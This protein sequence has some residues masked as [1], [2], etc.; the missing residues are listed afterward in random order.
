MALNRTKLAVTAIGFLR[1]GTNSTCVFPHCRGRFTCS[2]SQALMRDSYGISR[3]FDSLLIR[4]GN[5]S[6]PWDGLRPEAM[7][8]RRT[9]VFRARQL[10]LPDSVE[11][12]GV[13][14]NTTIYAKRY[15]SGR[16][17]RT[18]SAYTPLRKTC[19]VER[20]W[21]SFRADFPKPEPPVDFR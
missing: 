20:C 11:H 9:F 6:G 7:D 13:N 18:P 10:W 5:A 4:S 19:T 17:C 15:S 3:L 2:A 8:S 14:R 16:A 12:R 21:K 1:P